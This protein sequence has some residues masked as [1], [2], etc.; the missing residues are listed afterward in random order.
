MLEFENTKGV[1]MLVSAISENFYQVPN[2]NKTAPVRK[3]DNSLETMFN[4]LPTPNKKNTSIEKLCLFESI[5]EW[6]NFCHQK[7][8]GGNLD[9]IA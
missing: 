8:L 3:N 2:I 4:S 6:K 1:V 5:N 7:I 9:V